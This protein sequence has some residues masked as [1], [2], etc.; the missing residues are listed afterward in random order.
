[1]S[2]PTISFE[3][4]PPRDETGQA[5][6]VEN[7]AAKL[8]QRSPHFFSVTYGAGG[9]T[10]DGT[11]QTVAALFDAG[12][13]AAPH[14][15]MGSDAVKAL[16]DQLDDYQSLGVKRIVT[17]RGDQPSGMG[18]NRFANNAESLVRIIRDRYGDAFELIVA[19]YPEVHP[20]GTSAASDF[21]YFKRKVDAG[22]SGAITQ[23]FYAPEAYY[24][25]LDACARHNLDIPVIP[26]IMPITNAESLFRF[27]DKAGADIPRWLRYALNDIEDESELINFGVE[28]VTDLCERLL[29]MGAPGLHF[30]TLN[31]WGA[32]SRICDNLKIN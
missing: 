32:T 13:S 23:Y 29:S 28:V 26:G 2:T 1:M 31:R 24:R 9:S 15:S 20:D 21:D 14:L 10:R 17:L 22:A 4:F 16:Y 8:A 30:Y 3:F 7:V 19:A 12:Y 5:R 11:R 27:S 18:S 25:F 6:L